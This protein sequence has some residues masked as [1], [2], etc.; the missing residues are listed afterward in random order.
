MRTKIT[1]KEGKGCG[2][3]AL[4]FFQCIEKT[5]ALEPWD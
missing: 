4:F 1:K 5:G 3:E 2:M